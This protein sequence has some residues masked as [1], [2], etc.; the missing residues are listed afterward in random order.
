MINIKDVIYRNGKRLKCV[1]T[2]ENGLHTFQIID[3]NGN[4]VIISYEKGLFKI[5]DYGIRLIR[6]EK[7]Y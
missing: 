3:E 5:K 1:R 6:C 7:R 4:P 2:R